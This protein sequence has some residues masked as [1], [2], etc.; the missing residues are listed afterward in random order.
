MVIFHCLQDLP[1]LHSGKRRG[2]WRKFSLLVGLPSLSYRYAGFTW[3]ANLA[4]ATAVTFIV[5]HFFDI[6][7]GSYQVLT[8]GFLVVAGSGK[9]PNRATVNASSDMGLVMKSVAWNL[10]L[11]MARSMSPWPVSMI[12]SVSG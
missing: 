10:R 6:L 2:R 11:S 7:T 4:E 1:L 3:H 9:R 8:A 12:T 5:I